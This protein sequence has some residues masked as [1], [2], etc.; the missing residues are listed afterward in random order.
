MQELVR[1]GCA[2]GFAGDRADAGLPIVAELAGSN[3]FLVF[4][5]LAERTLALCQL[6]KRRD[7]ARG[8]SPALERMLPIVLGPA[9]A[10]GIRIVGNFGGANPRAAAVRIRAL[11]RE[12]GFPK[13]RV[14][15]VEGDDLT[16]S[17][18][19]EELAARETGGQCWKIARRSWLRTSISA[20]LQSPRRW[21][22]V[23]MW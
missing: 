13:A 7:A 23:P 10:N 14:A 1:I 8:Y 3:G 18:S 22:A 9:L 17:F 11:A 20:L 19:P 2:S 12:A 4:E 15:V 6:E 16:A 5:T 21:I